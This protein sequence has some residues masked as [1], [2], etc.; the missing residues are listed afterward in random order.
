MARTKNRNPFDAKG[1]TGE[2]EISPEIVKSL[3]VGVSSEVIQADP[4]RLW[5]LIA[6]D[7]MGG[8]AYLWP[9]QQSD[10][11]GIRVDTN[12]KS[13]LIHN[14]SYPSLVQGVWY[15]MAGGAPA[16]IR[17]IAATTVSSQR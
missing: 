3:S 11:Y 14:A 15:G 4:L 7:N 6:I 9:N 2:I 1:W 17:I 13:I 12:N 10:L 5:M 16:D 8:E